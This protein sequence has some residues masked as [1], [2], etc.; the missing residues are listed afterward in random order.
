MVAGTILFREIERKRS[1]LLSV[2]LITLFSCVQLFDVLLFLCSFL[3]NF[4]S[5]LFGI[6]GV[7]EQIFY[8]F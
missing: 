5:H 1:I 3:H 7:Y 4:F 6:I 8:I 2:I